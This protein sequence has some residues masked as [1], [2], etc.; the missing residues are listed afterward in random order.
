MNGLLSDAHIDAALDPST[1]LGVHGRARRPRAG[2]LRGGDL[3]PARLH[4]RLE[5]PED[6]PVLVLSNSLGTSLEMWDD[7]APAL[8][9][10]FRLLRFDSRGHGRSEVPG[11]PLC[12][13][14]TWA[15]TCWR[16]WT[17]WSSSAS[18]SAGCPWA[19]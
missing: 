18:T 4:H 13:S 19:A 7:Q 5:G 17:T 9:E 16:C 2:P 1:Y 8:A 6:A 11:R 15:A 12:R 14:R 3:M 10:H